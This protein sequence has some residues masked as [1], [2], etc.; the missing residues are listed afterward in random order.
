MI[1]MESAAGLYST[2][3]MSQSMISYWKILLRN[4]NELTISTI[5]NHVAT[6][7]ADV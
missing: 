7:K 2:F 6:K 3:F 1:E 5:L 4:K